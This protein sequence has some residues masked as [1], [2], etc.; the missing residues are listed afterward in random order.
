MISCDFKVSTLP[1]ESYIES[2]I[3]SIEFQNLKSQIKI[4]RQN[5]L[6][7]YFFIL[8]PNKMKYQFSSKYP[9]PVITKQKILEIN[10]FATFNNFYCIII[11]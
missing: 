1:I 8:Y 10:H 11:T 2:L 5:Q 7:D 3:Y 6:S 4:Y 9:F